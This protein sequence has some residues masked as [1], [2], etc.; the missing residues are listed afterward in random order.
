MVGPSLPTIK[1]LYSVSGNKCA[2]PKCS[3]PLVDAISGKVTGRICH[4]KASSAGGPRYDA[5]QSN[6][7]KHGFDNLVLMCP[8]HHDVI[9]ADEEAYTV[10]RLQKIKKE[11][12]LQTVEIKEVPDI[13]ATGFINNIHSNTINHGSIIFT[14]NQ[15]GGQVAHSITNVG[16]QSRQI[17]Q[18]AANALVAELRRY[19]SESFGITSLMSDAETY[20]TASM[21]EQILKATGWTTD[22]ISQAMFSGLPRDIIMKVPQQKESLLALLNWFGNIGFKPQGVLEPTLTRLEIIV[23]TALQ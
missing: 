22:G 23:G 15:M 19:P 17:S 11:H 6:Q 3:T 21:I 18:A 14:Q 12:E 5:A 1:R 7:E 8:V 16:P 2:F 20:Q 10:G 13:I 9:D 4:I